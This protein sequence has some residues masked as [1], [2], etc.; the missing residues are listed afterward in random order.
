MF[1]IR[2]KAGL[3]IATVAAAVLVALALATSGAVAGSRSVQG[4][5]VDS[6]VADGSCTA[7]I[8][9]RGVYTGTIRGSFEFA[10]TSLTPTDLPNVQSF[11]GHSTIH[12]AKGD[13]RCADSGSFNAD[14]NSSGEGVHLCVITG[15]TGRYAGAT[16]YL[17]ERLHFVGTEGQGIYVGNV[18]R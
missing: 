5:V 6:V 7:I 13:L 1:V 15:G 17:Q 4:E 14:P 8:C 2:R 16:G 3:A 9:T 18:S 11:A 10:I 12:T